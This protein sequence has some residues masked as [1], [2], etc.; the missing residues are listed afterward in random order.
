MPM[1]RVHVRSWQA[2]YRGLLP[3]DY[4]DSLKAEERAARYNFSD[5]DGPFPRAI[6]AEDDG[7]VVGLAMK[8]PCRDGSEAGELY[9]IYVDPAHW[10]HGAGR[11][12][13]STS[14]RHLYGQ[15]YRQAV[16]WALKGNDRARRFYLADGWELDGGQKTER[17]WGVQVEEERYHRALA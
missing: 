8:G 9:A 11:L 4:L 15:G 2:A 14:R 16:L 13:M 17:V 12:L 1:A 10:S 3:E 6:V 5:Q 7:V